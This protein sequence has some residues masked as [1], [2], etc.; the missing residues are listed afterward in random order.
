MNEVNETIR[1]LDKQITEYKIKQAQAESAY[2]DFSLK[3]QGQLNEA[4]FDYIS[5]ILYKLMK[6]YEYQYDESVA[7]KEEIMK[8]YNIQK[9]KDRENRFQRVVGGMMAYFELQANSEL[10]WDW[11]DY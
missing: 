6:Y 4:V 8:K 5:G 3:C 2:D 11:N 7:A 10:W 1:V 9:F